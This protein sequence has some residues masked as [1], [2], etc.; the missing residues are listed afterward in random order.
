MG[1]AGEG[2]IEYEAEHIADHELAKGDGADGGEHQRPTDG[3]AGGADVGE[4]DDRADDQAVEDDRHGGGV[5][6]MVAQFAREDGGEQRRDRAQRHVVPDCAADQI[7]EQAADEQAGHGVHGQERQ[8]HQRFGDAELHR[9][10]GDGLKEDREQDVEGGDQ[11][12]AGQGTGCELHCDDLPSILEGQRRKKRSMEIPCP[13]ARARERRRA[14]PGFVF[15]GAN[16]PSD[17]RASNCLVF[18][19]R[20]IIAGRLHARKRFC[21]T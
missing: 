9:A 4:I 6:G 17:R 7:C 2:L 11:R 15:S 12:R 5:D 3:R 8:Q 1:E 19:S 14:K 21:E 10:E 13:F 18:N 20:I 16:A